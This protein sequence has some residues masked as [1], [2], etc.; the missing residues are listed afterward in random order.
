MIDTLVVIPCYNAALTLEA[1]VVSVRAQGQPNTHI[2]LVD[3]CS[4]DG[5]TWSLIQDLAKRHAEVSAHQ[6]PANGGPAAARNLG[7]RAQDCR[8]LAFLDAD[9]QYLPGFLSTAIR[10]LEGHDRVDAVKIGIEIDPPVAID[11][12]RYA[13]TVR[14]VPSNLVL[15]RWVFDFLGGFPEDPIFRTPLAGEDVA[16]QEALF[17]L[18]NV[19]NIEERLLLHHCPPN[20]HFHRFLA[21]TRV[22]N[23]QLIYPESPERLEIGR[24]AGRFIT[25]A[26]DQA[27]AAMQ[28]SL[29]RP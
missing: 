27:R 10:Y 18:F 14:S 15:R 5:R 28:A 24:A 21:E 13:A 7:A 23:G 12:I 3:D 29:R 19:L 4:T 1:A 8:F 16:F 2:A 6:T 17:S 20:S 22:E 9:D 26:R 25:A 11:P